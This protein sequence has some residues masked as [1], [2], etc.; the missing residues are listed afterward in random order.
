METF[1]FLS[2][3][4]NRTFIWLGAVWPGTDVMI[5]IFG[6]KWHF[7]QK[8]MLW[9]IFWHNSALFWVENAIFFAKY[10]GENIFKIFTSVPDWANFHLHIGWLVVSFGHVFENDRSS[11]A[12]CATFSLGTS[13]VIILTGNSLG[14]ILGDFS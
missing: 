12:S 5:T 13:Y 8:T 3:E 9:S 10:F 4:A 1:F 7:S 11:T 2:P 6:K 14:H